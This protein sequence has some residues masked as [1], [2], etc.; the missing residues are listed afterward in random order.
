MNAI[1]HQTSPRF[2]CHE[3]VQL[4]KEFSRHLSPI[5][6]FWDSVLHMFGALSPV[7]SELVTK[8]RICSQD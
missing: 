8:R 4:S 6:P 1:A 5:S 3:S 2:K 7:V